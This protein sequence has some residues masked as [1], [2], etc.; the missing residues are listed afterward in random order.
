M[1]VPVTRIHPKITRLHKRKRIQIGF[2]NESRAVN[3]L[4]FDSRVNDDLHPENRRNCT[5]RNDNKITRVNTL[6]DS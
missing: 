1:N 5:R 3:I 2:T 4:E 6:V